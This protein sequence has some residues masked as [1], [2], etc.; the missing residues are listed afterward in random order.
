MAKRKLPRLPDEM[1][2]RVCERFL[3]P[4]PES[5]T[6]LAA[7][8]TEELRGEGFDVRVTRQQIYELVEE[9][10]KRSFFHMR[11]PLNVQ[12]QRSIAAKYPVNIGRI[13]VVPVGGAPALDVVAMEAAEVA[14]RLMRSIAPTKRR[15]VHVGLGAGF[16]TR[17][18]VQHLVTL[19]SKERE[20]PP[21]ALHA[22][23][24][25]FDGD[26][27]SVAPMAFFGLFDTLGLDIEYIGLF[28]PSMVRWQ[29]YERVKRQ[30]GARQAFERAGEVDIVITSLAS[31]QDAHGTLNSFL[32]GV[33]EDIARLSQAGWVGDLQY[34][35][36]SQRGPLLVQT[37]FRAVTLFEL[38]DLVTM[39]RS[40]NR[41][42][43]VAAAPCTRCGQTRSAALHALLSVPG[44]RL[45]THL[46]TDLSTAR[47]LLKESARSQRLDRHAGRDALRAGGP[48]DGAATPRPPAFP[49]GDDPRPALGNPG[50]GG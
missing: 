42:V 33:P 41:S 29:D 11:P 5:A 21:L 47:E 48:T 4:E 18:I 13:A 45:T 12:L 7:W 16:T 50:A 30:P 27:P 31:A 46:V 38:S 2:F 34:R 1:L 9:A 19:L 8:L 28:A 26:Q 44:L 17:A 3:A 23:S 25:G 15:R 35:P 20:P 32:A 49:G 14:L 39:V 40:A 24:T 43:I 10:R 22:L 6:G 36:Y 37:R